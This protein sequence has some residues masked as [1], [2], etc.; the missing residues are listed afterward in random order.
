M[1]WNQSLDK[2]RPDWLLWIALGS[3]GIV[4]SVGLVVTD[5]WYLFWQGTRLLV[6]VGVVVSVGS[7]VLIGL[8]L[9]DGLDQI[10]Y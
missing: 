8:V 10:V 5:K 2:M 6:P 9:T 1:G 4:L 3:V 7:V